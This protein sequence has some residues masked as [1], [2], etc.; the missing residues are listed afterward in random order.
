MFYKGGSDLISFLRKLE[1]AMRLRPLL[2]GRVA[3]GNKILVK[4]LR[5][6][7]V[8]GSGIIVIGE[9]R[10]RTGQGLSGTR[11]RSDSH[12]VHSDKCAFC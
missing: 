5:L 7:R 3:Y 10:E 4:I 8:G 9:L 2:A 6:P 1:T 11:Q 12:V